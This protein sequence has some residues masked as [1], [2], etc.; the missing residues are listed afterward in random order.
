VAV[1]PRGGECR[2]AYENRISTALMA[3]YRDTRDRLVFE[4]LYSYSRSSVEQWI[5][6]LLGRDL[7]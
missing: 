2:D 4:A 5:S 1:E 3:L 7:L 6:S